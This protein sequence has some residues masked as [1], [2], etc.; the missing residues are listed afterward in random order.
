[1]KFCLQAYEALVTEGGRLKL[2]ATSPHIRSRVTYRTGKIHTHALVQTD[3]MPASIQNMYVI[4]RIEKDIGARLGVDCIKWYYS[5]VT[6]AM[7]FM[8]LR[9]SPLKPTL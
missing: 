1:M 7:S 6:C 4:V 5:Y 9:C 3:P 8:R 2:L